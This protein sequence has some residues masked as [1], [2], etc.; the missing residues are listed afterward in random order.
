[1]TCTNVKG[2]LNI[3]FTHTHTKKTLEEMQN[4]PSDSVFGLEAYSIKEN[5]FYTP[6]ENAK[7]QV[8]QSC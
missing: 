3:S 5:I 2:M 6:K 8:K 7:R 1:M 4:H